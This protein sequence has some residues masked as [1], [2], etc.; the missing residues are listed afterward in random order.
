MPVHATITPLSVHSLGG[1]KHGI[2]PLFLEIL[3]KD[4]L[5]YLLDATPPDM[6]K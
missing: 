4:F 2:N 5:I 6:T 1:G 3:I